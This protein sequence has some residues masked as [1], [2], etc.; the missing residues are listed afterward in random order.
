[1]KS[2]YKNIEECTSMREIKSLRKLE[3]TNLIKLKEVILANSELY[4]VFDFV[5]TNLY[6]VYTR[7]QE[8]NRTLT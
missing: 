2:K 7:A 3:H 4:L 6:Q 8:S 5:E 1:M